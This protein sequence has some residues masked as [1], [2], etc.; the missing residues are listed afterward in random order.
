M[1]VSTKILIFV[2][3]IFIVGTAGF[4][5]YKQHEISA[6]Q[7]AIEKGIVAQ[8]ELADNILRSMS[9]YTTKKELEE[10]AKES[11]INLGA[12]RSDLEKLNANVVAI[13]IAKSHSNGQV[14]NNVPSTNTNPGDNPNPPPTEQD[15]YGYQ[16]NQQILSINETFDNLSVPIGEV[17]FSAWKEKPW[18]LNIKP[19]EYNSSTVIGMDENQRIYT[20]NKFSIKVDNKDYEIKISKGEVQQ[21]YPEAK[22]SWWNPRLFLGFDGGVNIGKINGTAAPSLNVQIMS[23]GKYKNQPDF[24]I[25]QIGGGYDIHNQKP[26]AVITPFS[27]NIGKHIPLLNNT[28][29]GP[30][31]LINTSGDISVLAGIRVGL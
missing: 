17:G 27:Y 14:T 6:R 16:K 4:V 9:Q 25:L 13:N 2:F 29:I 24:S 21:V 26:G 31:V 15:P 28:Y 10:F 8:R 5:I 11:N 12:I 30:S 22:W 3:A 20:Y 1:T 7:D 23:Y 18:S 19:R